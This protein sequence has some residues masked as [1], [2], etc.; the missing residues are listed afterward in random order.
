MNEKLADME[1]EQAVRKTENGGKAR[2]KGMI[3]G[4]VPGL[5]RDSSD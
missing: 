1:E 3:A 4:S 2:S 5:K